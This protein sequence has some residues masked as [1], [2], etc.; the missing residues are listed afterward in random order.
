MREININLL[1]E[2]KELEERIQQLKS[3]HPLSDREQTL[4]NEMFRELS[5]INEILK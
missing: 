4:L 5:K 2:R 1:R 3:K